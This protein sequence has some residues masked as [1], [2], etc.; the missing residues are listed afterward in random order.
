MSGS[1]AWTI[2]SAEPEVVLGADGR[3]QVSVTVTNTGTATD[4]AVLDVVP[5]DGADRSWFTVAEPQRQVPPGTSVP[6]LVS[7]AVPAGTPP[8]TRWVAAR[9]WSADGSP[10]DSSVLSGRVAFTI[11][12]TAAPPRKRPLWIIPVVVLVVVVLAVVGFLV[13]RN[14]DV[15]VPNLAQRTVAEATTDLADLGLQLGVQKRRQDP[16]G[17]GHVLA[18]ST[19]VG[20]AVSKGT[21]IDVEVGVDLAAPS[22]LGP[23]TPEAAP[24]GAF[25]LALRWEPVADARSYTIELQ[26]NVCG[27]IGCDVFIPEG[28]A[29]TSETASASAVVQTA[30]RSPIRRWR[31]A[32][33]DDFGNTGPFSDYSYISM[34]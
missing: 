23:I 17:A 20:A 18:Q 7:I 13:L 12:P 25:R 28:P 21:A 31:V 15:I 29:L 33:V 11:P 32:G 2:T 24:P 10:E 1:A 27:I 26:R 19:A 14:R 30:F 8:A 16:A 3:A 6:Y 9:V 22:P 5:G 34:P 4:R